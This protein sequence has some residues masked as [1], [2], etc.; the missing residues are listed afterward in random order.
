MIGV[1]GTHIDGLNSR[2]VVAVTGRVVITARLEMTT[3]RAL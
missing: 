3:F 1:G 2:G